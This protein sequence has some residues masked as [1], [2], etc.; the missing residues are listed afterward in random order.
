MYC[1][2]LPDSMTL[3]CVTSTIDQ[4]CLVAALDYPDVSTHVFH[5]EKKAWA[6]YTRLDLVA[7]LSNH[8]VE[9]ANVLDYPAMLAQV[10]N[11]VQNFKLDQRPLWE[12]ERK[13]DKKGLPED[14]RE[15]VP[16]LERG[17][18]SK[19]TK[20]PSVPAIPPLPPG[21]PALP[22]GIP[23]L[24]ATASHR[25]PPTKGATGKVWEIADRCYAERSAGPVMD[26][27]ALRS[28]VVALCEAEGLN[29]GTAATQFAKWKNSK[30]Y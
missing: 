6:R 13:A 2:V 24:P 17:E 5:H 25:A 23:K 11:L 16:R 22:A 30:G 29:P 26:M 7:F 4:A 1:I 12:L 10:D 28:E 15:I 19:P 27:K 14:T 3:A 18:L 9:G 8:S 21:V 20:M